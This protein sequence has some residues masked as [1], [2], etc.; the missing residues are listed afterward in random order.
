MIVTSISP[1]IFPLYFR[2]F[3][4]CV[5]TLYLLFVYVILG[6]R[7][8]NARRTENHLLGAHIMKL[9]LAHIAGLRA[10]LVVLAYLGALAK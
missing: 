3:A 6:A 5:C 7:Y 9:P 4:R 10:S 8:N 2:L 1:L